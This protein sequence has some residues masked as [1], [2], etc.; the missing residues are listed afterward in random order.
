MMETDPVARVRK[1]GAWAQV[2]VQ[3]RC[4]CT[5]PSCSWLLLPHRFCWVGLITP[6][7]FGLQYLTK[8]NQAHFEQVFGSVAAELGYEDD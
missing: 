6:S 8:N 5:S 3:Q 4:T 2:R 1:A 7:F